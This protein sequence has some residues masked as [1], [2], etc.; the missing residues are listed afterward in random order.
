MMFSVLFTDTQVDLI[1]ALKAIHLSQVDD[2]VF[3]LMASLFATNA[4]LTRRSATNRDVRVSNKI[5]HTPSF[6]G[7][8]N[9]THE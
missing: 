7:T 9:V 2:I 3:D 1:D 5:M 6:V 4:A 8:I